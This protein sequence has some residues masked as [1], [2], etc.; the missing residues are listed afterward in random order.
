VDGFDGNL[1]AI[2][3]DKVVRT[4][5]LRWFFGLTA[6]YVV[7]IVIANLWP[8]LATRAFM[9]ITALAYLVFQLYWVFR[10]MREEEQRITWRIWND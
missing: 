1:R 10:D 6:A 2:Y 5:R 9:V 8:S 4:R 3:R 7:G